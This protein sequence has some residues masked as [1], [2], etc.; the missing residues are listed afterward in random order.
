MSTAM[1]TVSGYYLWNIE[2]DIP[3]YYSLKSKD[4]SYVFNLALIC[5]FAYHL[6]DIVR[7]LMVL[8]YAVCKVETE[9]IEKIYECGALNGCFGIVVFV[10]IYQRF[11]DEGEYCT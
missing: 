6:M 7:C 10:L 3:C 11:T 1:A 5:V 9:F 8:L 4:M 2:T